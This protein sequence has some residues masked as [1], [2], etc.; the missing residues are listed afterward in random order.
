MGA[1]LSLTCGI[2]LDTVKRLR[3]QQKMQAYMDVCEG[4]R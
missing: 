2:I 4:E 1:A 3:I